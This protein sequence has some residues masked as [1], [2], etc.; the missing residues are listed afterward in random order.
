[1]GARNALAEIFLESTGVKAGGT[2][3]RNFWLIVTLKMWARKRILLL[4]L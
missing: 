1:M 4:Q 3:K 2:N